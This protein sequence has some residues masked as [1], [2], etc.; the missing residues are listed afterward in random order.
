MFTDSRLNFLR[1]YFINLEISL[2]EYLAK[3]AGLLFVKIKY[4]FRIF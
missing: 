4:I 2:R 1:N 3:K